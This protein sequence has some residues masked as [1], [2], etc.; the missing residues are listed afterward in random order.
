MEA[1]EQGG[2]LH[3]ACVDEVADLRRPSPR[4]AL[5]D[6]FVLL[7]ISFLS[8]RTPS[9]WPAGLDP[10]SPPLVLTPASPASSLQPSSPR[11]VT[12]VHAHGNRSII[13]DHS[14]PLTSFLV[15]MVNYTSNRRSLPPPFLAVDTVRLLFLLASISS[16]S[17]RFSSAFLGFLSF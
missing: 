15:I 3:N 10:L 5:D 8:R 16:P 7:G 17:Q 13:I 2:R 1:R 6:Q 14:P 11:L 9:A 4:T 12:I